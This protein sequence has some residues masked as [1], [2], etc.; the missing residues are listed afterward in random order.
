MVGVW[1]AFCPSRNAFHASGSITRSLGSG[2]SASSLVHGGGHA[3]LD[4]PL[5]EL[6]DAIEDDDRVAVLDLDLLERVLGETLGR[7][8][9]RV[10]CLLLAAA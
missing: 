10:A 6:L 2:C 8:E 7:V 3:E 5:L 1:L 4:G 9:T